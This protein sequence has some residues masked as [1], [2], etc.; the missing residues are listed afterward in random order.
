MSHLEGPAEGDLA[1]VVALVSGR[2]QGVG[3]RWWA[4]QRARHHGV[5]GRATNLRDGRVEVVVEGE[6]PACDA[7]VREIIGG[8]TPGR[9]TDVQVRWEEPAGEQGFGVG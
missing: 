1:R 3:F 4:T 6:R 2:V 9:V 7:L 5:A 8:P